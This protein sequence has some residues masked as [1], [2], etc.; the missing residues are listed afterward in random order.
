M[1]NNSDMVILN[2]NNKSPEITK[3]TET[4]LNISQTNQNMNSNNINTSRP[5][6][7]TNLNG[8][9][10]NN[11]TQNNLSAP[12]I[13]DNENKNININNIQ[14]INHNAVISANNMEYGQPVVIQNMQDNN[15]IRNEP[16]NNAPK[17]SIKKNKNTKIRG[18][19]DCCDAC[20]SCF[21]VCCS[22]C[23][24]KAKYLKYKK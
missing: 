4:L 24:G 8:N 20:L 13:I 23:S 19:R 6:I 14:N 10:G 18:E 16:V 3:N 5:Q 15:N 7:Y 21:G 12:R 22:S 11:S 2:I 1:A 9:I 17:V